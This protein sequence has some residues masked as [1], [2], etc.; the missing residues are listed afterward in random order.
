MYSDKVHTVVKTYLEL[1]VL[2]D[3]LELHVKNMQAA[4]LKLTPVVI[5]YFNELQNR[6]LK[7]INETRKIMRTQG[8]K[9]L[10][11][12]RLEDRLE[13]TYLCRG[14]NWSITLL[15]QKLQSDIEVKLAELMNVDIT[16]LKRGQ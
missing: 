5:L 12:N 3:E 1:P 2:L 8:I 7:E 13:A 4:D 14:Y 9:I 6:V 11:Q 16:Q 10:Q 15:N